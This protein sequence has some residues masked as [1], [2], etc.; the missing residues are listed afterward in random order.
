VSVGATCLETGGYVT[1][2]ET[3]PLDEFAMAVMA[4]SSI[5]GVFPYVQIPSGDPARNC[6]FCDGGVSMGID[7][8]SA[9][10]RC[11]ELVDSPADIVIDMVLCAS[12]NIPTKVITSSD[13]TLSLYARS[14]EIR[15]GAVNLATVNNV[16]ALYPTVNW[17]YLIM[18]TT[19]LPSMLDFSK[20]ALNT[21]LSAGYSDA[22][23]VIHSKKIY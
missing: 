10:T 9:V 4:S 6:S 22:S 1:W 3:Y 16:K 12:L 13:H 2:N 21:F 11:L 18:P 19:D 17:R 5:P 23:A 14:E 20:A 8:Q 15:R 7:L